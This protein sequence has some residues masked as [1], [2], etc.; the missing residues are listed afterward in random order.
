VLTG[1]EKKP[2]GSNCVTLKC[3]AKKF[4][5]KQQ[6]KRESNIWLRNAKNIKNT[7]CSTYESNSERYF[8]FRKCLGCQEWNKIRNNTINQNTS[9]TTTTIASTEA[10]GM[11]SV[12]IK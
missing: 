10:K 1:K 11:K 7:K 4:I 12:D 9:L 8:I 2:S 6:G 5:K 3:K